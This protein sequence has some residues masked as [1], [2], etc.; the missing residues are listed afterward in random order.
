[1]FKVG[2][3]VV[4]VRDDVR[5]FAN[6]LITEGTVYVIENVRLSV[7]GLPM[8]DLVGVSP[9]LWRGLTPYGFCVTRFRKVQRRDLQQWLATKNTIEEPKRIKEQA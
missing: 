8:V 5:V 1:M 6:R 9:P 7:N 2:D 4:C 3:E